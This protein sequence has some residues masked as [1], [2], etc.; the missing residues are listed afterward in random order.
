MGLL[1]IGVFICFLTYD[2]YYCCFRTD[3][4]SA[5]F[6]PGIINILN[7]GKNKGTKE[8]SQIGQDIVSSKVTAH[9]PT[10]PIKS[11]WRIFG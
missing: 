3:A 11:G 5:K 10:L 2:R 1:K 4:Q 8:I 6:F 9:L 7:T